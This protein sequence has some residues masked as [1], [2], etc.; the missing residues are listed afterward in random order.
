MPK[1][2]APK[3]ERRHRVE[4][5]DDQSRLIGLLWDRYILESVQDIPKVIEVVG[6]I[7]QHV[8]EIRHTKGDEYLLD[9][10]SKTK[11]IFDSLWEVHGCGCGNPGCGHNRDNP[12]NT[13]G[14][15]GELEK[16]N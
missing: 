9:M 7:H 5:S 13:L 16:L 12:D 14:G 3:L 2:P 15:F 10:W 6:C 8:E 4:L 11:D 1:G